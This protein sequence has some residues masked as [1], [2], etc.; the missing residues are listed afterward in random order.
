LRI[1]GTLVVRPVLPGRISGLARLSRNL[2][3]TWHHEAVRLWADIDRDL[4]RDSGHNPVALLARTDQARLDRLAQDPGFLERYDRVMGE[5]DGYM[6]AQDT[7]FERQHPDQAGRTYAYFAA[8]FGLHESLPIYSGGL[9]ILSGDHLKSASDLGVPLVGVGLL[10]N[11]GY[12]VQRINAEG[13]QEAVYEKLDFTSAPVE[14]ALDPEGHPVEVEVE[15]PDRT[16]RAQVWLVQVGRVRL[17]LLDTD[18]E[19][20]RPEDRRLSARLYGGDIHMRIAQEKILGLGGVRALRQLGIHPE[21]WHLNEGHS[22]FLTLELLRERVLAG[23]N[24]REACEAVAPGV[25]FT[26]HTPVPAGHDVFDRDL[27]ELHFSGLRQELG[28]SLDEFMELGQTGDPPEGPFSLTVLAL[29]LSRQRN[30]V[31]RL[32]GEVSRRLWTSVWPLLPEGE[33]PIGHITNGV[34]HTSWVAAEMGEL[35]DRYLGPGWRRD[36]TGADWSRLEQVPDDELW[37]VHQNLKASMIRH[38]RQKVQARLERL[39]LGPARRRAVDQMLHQEVL[40]LGFARRFATYKRAL[41]LFSDLERLLALV[42]HPRRPVRLVFAGKAHPADAPGQE[43]IR[44]LHELSLRPELQGHL[45]LV[46]DYDIETARRLVEGVDLWLNNPRRPLEAS[47]TSGQKASMNGVLNCSVLDGWWAEAYNGKNGWAIG[48]ERAYGSA[49]EQDLADA[50]SLYN[51]LENEV[52]P[53]YYERDEHGLPRGWVA[54]MKEAIRTLTPVYNTHRMVCDYTSQM[55]VP[56]CRKALRAA[57]EGYALARELARWRQEMARAWDEVELEGEGPGVSEATRGQRLQF[58][59]RARL[60]RLSPEQV[61]VEVVA[62]RLRE[63]ILEAPQTV[64]LECRGAQNG[65]WLFEGTLCPDQT[66]NIAYGLRLLP[67]HPALQGAHEVGLI[68]WAN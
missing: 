59:A 37:G 31:S 30:G 7:W 13:W 58:A 52:I 11:Q 64:S 61:R 6:R 21:V 48:E 42:N 27:M 49:E 53:L 45:L 50:A 40:T 63:G 67:V 60:G 2:W 41:L 28:M 44:R 39:G 4:W 56:A 15:M 43:L 66:G 22:A 29:R 3:W 17:Y 10:Y 19:R 36:P 35:F 24:W 26:T 9:G 65:S 62:G 8:E 38:V 20:N 47:G 32:H 18:V 16:V 57:A 68:R 33:V 5:F 34:H 23:L 1:L 25:C 12:F 51:V 46:E 55:Y 14:R 54:R